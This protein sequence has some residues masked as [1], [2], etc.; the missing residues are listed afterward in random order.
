MS[1]FQKM[2]A[3][4]SAVALLGAGGL[5]AAQAATGTSA[6]KSS[7][8]A[9]PHGKRGGGPMATAQLA[10]IAK[11]LGVTSAQLK[12]AMDASRPAKPTGDRPDRGAG[13]ATELATALG[14]DVAKVT[15]ILDANRPAKPAAGTRPPQGARPARPDNSKLVTALATGLGIDEATVKAAFDKLDAAHKADHSAR[16]TAMYA[17]VAK[18]LGLTSD[19]VKAAF[20]ANR[21]AK[22]AK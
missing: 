10:A 8:S 18:E 3:T 12:A 11:T 14:V 5:S 9:R 15:A 20:D 13:M 19:A 22:P 6:A 21:P 17:T 7:S 2:T 1:R 4:V 16:E